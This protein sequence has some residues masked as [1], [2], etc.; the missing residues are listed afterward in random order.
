MSTA[1]KILGVSV[2]NSAARCTLYGVLKREHEQA[3]NLG[4]GVQFL[5]YRVSPR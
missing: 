2:N 4:D 5:V 1:E 3:P